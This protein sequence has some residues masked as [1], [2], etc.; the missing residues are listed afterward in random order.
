[1]VHSITS[2]SPVAVEQLAGWIR[3]GHG[4]QDVPTRLVEL[5]SLRVNRL[6]APARRVLQSVA[7]NGSVADRHLV[8]ATLDDEERATLRQPELWTGLLIID[9]DRLTIPTDVVANVVNACTP[10][11]V[12][13]RLHRRVYR[14]C[15]ARTPAGR[16]GHHA[17][18]SGEIAHAYELFLQAGNDAVRRFDDP[19]A[20]VWYGRAVACARALHGRAV[21]GAM[22]KLAEASVLLA[23]VL[24]QSG[25]LKLATGTCEEA[26]L[27]GPNDQQ[28]A[29]IERTLG[30]ISLSAGRADESVEQLERAI[31]HALRA[32]DRNF[33]CQ[34]YLDLMNSLDAQGRS[35]EATSELRQAIDV[36]TMGEGLRSTAGPSRLWRL[37]LTLAER[38]RA[39]GDYADAKV[40]AATALTLATRAGNSH[41]R[42]RIS[43]LLAKICEDSGE[44][45][46]A[47]RHRAQA[48]DA[49]RT[50]GD[51]RSTAEL[52]IESARTGK[53]PA[54]GPE[55]NPASA[56]RLARKLA[57]EVGWSEGIDLARQQQA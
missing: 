33:L 47:L 28:I 52:L 51:R 26:K 38:L 21:D 7:I 18:A 43:A 56:L 50:L 30:V 13:R 57:H 45:G 37:G 53:Q 36:I 23:E 11:D 35:E 2:G 3:L 8:E 5:V 49:M 34:C 29:M 14:A 10:A 19:G 16:W 22:T 27:L 12:C 17:E 4:T 46:L 31:G 55:G 40:T 42:G 39:A 9:L 20:A 25:E 6:P 1:V 54:Q 24:R 15:S 32:G 44:L 48:I 41:A